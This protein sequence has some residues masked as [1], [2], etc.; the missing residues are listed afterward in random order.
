MKNLLT[1]LLILVTS[2]SF[3]QDLKLDHSYIDSAPFAVGDTIT[4]KF[5]TLDVNSSVPTLVQFDYQYNNKLLEKIDHTFKLPSNP[6]AMTSLNHW[7]GYLW[8]P[9]SNVTST[10][11]SGQYQQGS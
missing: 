1:M 6:S 8:T 11:L 10:N 5:N 7:D 3:G 2:I 9:S 4:I